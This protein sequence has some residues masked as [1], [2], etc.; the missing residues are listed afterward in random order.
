MECILTIDQGNSRTKATYFDGAGHVCVR[1][2]YK[3]SDIEC[4]LEDYDCYPID[5][6]IY[7]S[8]GHVDVRLI[9][10]IRLSYPERLL[11][12][13]HHTPVG[14]K[15]RY[16]HSETLGSDRV[17]A[18]VG[19]AYLRAGE[20]VLVVDAGTAITMDVV[21]SGREFCGGNISAGISLRMKALHEATASLPEVHKDGE[22]PCFG[23]DTETAIR[24][25]A[26][27]GAAWEIEGAY[28][29]A[30]RDYGCDHV[31]L[32]GGDADILQQY[33][34]LPE[35]TVSVEPDLVAIGLREILRRNEKEL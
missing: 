7:S 19:A 33:L 2:V 29:Q 26:L 23:Y 5:G 24:S 3:S 21:D 28:R 31:I 20:S 34:L 16:R 15:V 30:N 9:E 13:T 17:A 22:A 32:T 8:V 25:G 6:V 35:G 27:H 14:I 18:A 1:N 10:S 4:L 12:F 11:V